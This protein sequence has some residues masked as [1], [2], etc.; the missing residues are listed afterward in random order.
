MVD[1]SPIVETNIAC[2]YIREQKESHADSPFCLFLSWGPPHWNSP[3]RPRRYGEYPQEFDVYDPDRIRIPENEPRP[4]EPFA[5]KELADYYG[6]TTSI[7]A[8]MGRL[9]EQLDE[10]G[11]REETIVC[12]TSDHGDHLFAHGMQTG[13]D[14][15]CHH[16]QA[17]SKATMYDESIHVPFILRYPGYI[18]EDTRKDNLFSSVDI[19]LTLLSLCN[20][21]SRMKFKERI[22]PRFSWQ[23]KQ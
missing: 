15:W 8:C 4:L 9:M 17:G 5:R 1:F 3:D 2:R 14:Q 19:M 22:I 12:F 11:I 16:T 23:V 18:P 21:P 7:D 6:M 20:I 13:A 10:S